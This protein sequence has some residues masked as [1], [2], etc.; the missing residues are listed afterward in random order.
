MSRASLDGPWAFWPDLERRLPTGPGAPFVTP[1]ERDA[2][3][4]SPRIAHVPGP[5]QAQFEDL[6]SWAGTAW[7][8][9]HFAVPAEWLRGRVRLCFGAVDYFTTVWINARLAGEHEGGYLPFKFDVTDLLRRDQANTVTLRVL[10]V[11]PHQEDGPFP[12]SQIPHG[13]Q[14]WYGPI[15]GP[16][17]PVR[18]EGRGDVLIDAVRIDAELH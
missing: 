8:E 5:W 13:K 1:E 9:R 11:G 17:Q 4:G 16:W 12:F 6:R 15:G 3:L 7:Y 2:A 14:S 10:D 18:L